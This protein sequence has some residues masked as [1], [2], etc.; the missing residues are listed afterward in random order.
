MNSD[1]VKI[2][3]T[4]DNSDIIESLYDEITDQEVADLGINIEEDNFAILNDGQANFFL[5]KLEETKNEMDRIN[6]TCNSEIEKFTSRVNAFRNKEIVGLENTARYFSTL[7]EA[8]AKKQLEGSKKKSMK[9]PFGTMS[10]KKGQQK[11]N[12]DDE[13]I[14][15]YLHE[16]NLVEFIRTKE[17]IDK[18]NLKSNL[19]VTEDGQAKLGDSIVEGIVIT[20]GEESFNI[21]Q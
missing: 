20:P 9:L 6:N 2:F 12:Y 11:F 17:E 10:F 18:K 7:L 8:Y 5:R 16:N 19:T 14:M 3:D 4:F 15:K 21:K 13:A 1:D